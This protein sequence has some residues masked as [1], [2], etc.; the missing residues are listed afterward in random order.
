MQ[1][2][3]VLHIEQSYHPSP[4]AATTNRAAQWRQRTPRP[5]SH[6][7]SLALQFLAAGHT[8]TQTAALLRLHRYTLTRW[9]KYPLFQAQLDRRLNTPVEVHVH[10]HVTG[11]T[12]RHIAPQSATTQCDV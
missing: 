7:Q 1:L 10:D 11:A 9:L 2:R 4:A 6:R 3:R 8:L 5:L 12:K